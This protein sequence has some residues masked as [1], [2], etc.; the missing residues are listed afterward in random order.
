MEDGIDDDLS[1]DTSH[2]RP[3]CLAMNLVR[4]W[5]SFQDRS[6][7]YQAVKKDGEESCWQEIAQDY[8][9]IVYPNHQ[10]ENLFSRLL[11]RLDGI[12]TAIEI[13]SGPGS[14]TLPLAKRLREVTAVE[15][16]PAMAGVLEERLARQKAE[17][18]TVVKRRWEE[19][20]PPP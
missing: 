12:T 20:R 6:L 16:S 10:Q 8:D 18:V 1:C 13:G 15:P 3:V 19:A 2:I 4:K 14:L 11:P 17:N 9:Q 7:Y 5:Q